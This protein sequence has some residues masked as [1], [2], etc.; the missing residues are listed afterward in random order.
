MNSLRTRHLTQVDCG[1]G[2]SDPVSFGWESDS[3][4]TSAHLRVNW[5]AAGVGESDAVGSSWKE[6]IQPQ[7]NTGLYKGSLSISTWMESEDQTACRTDLR[8][9]EPAGRESF[10][11][12]IKHYSQCYGFQ[13][14]F[15][16]TKRNVFEYRKKIR[17]HLFCGLVWGLCVFS[18]HKGRKSTVK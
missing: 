10:L 17:P 1:H 16:G 15:T 3:C 13:V 12:I 4:N 18:K 7:A 6:F 2:G 5:D 14:I 9:M 8:R 11:R